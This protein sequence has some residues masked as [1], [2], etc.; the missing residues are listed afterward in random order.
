MINKVCILPC[1]ANPLHAGHLSM[2]HYVESLG[3][4]VIFELSTTNVDKAPISHEERQKRI[5]QFEQLG[6]EYIEPNA[7]TF[8]QKFSLTVVGDDPPYTFLIGSDTLSRIQDK[9]Y[10]FES[11]KEM[12]RILK[13]LVDSGNNFLV[14]ARPNKIESHPILAP[15]VEWADM[16][17]SDISSSKIREHKNNLRCGTY[18]PNTILGEIKYGTWVYI[19]LP[20]RTCVELVK[21]IDS[22]ENQIRVQL[23]EDFFFLHWTTECMTRD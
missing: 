15:I 7:P 17:P 8:F 19:Q 22:M 16:E 20:Y 2:A 4:K 14:F 18:E 12:E 21:V 6:R 11:E 23:N 9:K 3:S 10:Y 1:S 5:G 13:L